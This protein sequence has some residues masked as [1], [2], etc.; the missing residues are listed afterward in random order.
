MSPRPIFNLREFPPLNLPTYDIALRRRSGDGAIEVY[1]DL[2][3]IWAMLTPEEWVR[4]HFTHYLISRLG[5][6]DIRMANEVGLRFNRTVRR[7]D[8]VIYDDYARPVAIVEYKA[9]AVTVSQNT[10]DQIV[11]YNLVLKAPYLFVSNGLRHYCVK[12]NPDSGEYH[13]LADLPQYDRIVGA[14]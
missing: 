9:P 7:C 2:R 3:R 12:V 11:R 8:T 10:F 14:E 5:Y 13:F 1:D 6:P 4:Q